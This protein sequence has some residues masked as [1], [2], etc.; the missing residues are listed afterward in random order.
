[1]KKI[2]EKISIIIR[3]KNEERWIE[4]CLKKIFDQN[5]DNFEVILVDNNSKDKTLEKAKKFPV[6]VIKINKFL[7][8]KAINLGIK[9]ST[10]K[11]IVCLSAHC[12]PINNNW[13]KKIIFALK[14]PNVAGVYGRQ[15]PLSYSSDFDKRDLFNLFGP[16]KKIQRKDTFFHNANSA[17]K[18][19][20]WSKIPFDEK[21]KHIEDRIWGNQV[22]NKGYKIIYEPN[23]PVYHW[24]GINQDMEPS[25]CKRIVNILESLNQ[26]FKSNILENEINPNCVAIIPLRGET[27]RIDNKL[28]L[29]DVT[30]SHLKKSKLIKD[31]YLATDNKKSKKI[32]LD[33]NIKVPFLRPKYLS[34]TFIDIK[35]ILTF[36]LDRLEKKKTIDIVD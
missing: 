4:Q 25:R 14:D 5:Y 31:I 19:K 23:A 29:L 35:S 13:L 2:A 12:I 32:G 30:V 9:K 10:G 27:L 24:H 21:T 28:S 6:K 11:I 15:K 26:D 34:D 36:F 17:F 22:I 3:T 8:G 18:K 7:P 16:E 20:L 33:A 1:M